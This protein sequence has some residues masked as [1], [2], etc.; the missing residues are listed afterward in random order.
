[1]NDPLFR[2]LVAVV[3]LIETLFIVQQSIQLKI[4]WIVYVLIIPV[5]GLAFFIYF[6]FFP[7]DNDM[8]F[9]SI[10]IL[11]LLYNSWAK[12]MLRASVIRMEK[13]KS[14]LTQ[15]DLDDTNL[16]AL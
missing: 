5:C 3:F 8:L 15:M 7:S 1:M 6:A 16:M 2:I 4:K 12:W 10:L 13:E 9:Y 14:K 11:N